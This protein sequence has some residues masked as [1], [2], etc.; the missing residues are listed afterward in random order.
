M[1]TD[2]RQV[3][4][5]FGSPALSHLASVSVEY[6]TWATSYAGVLTAAAQAEAAHKTARAKFMLAARATGECRSMTEAETR[7]EADDT[8]A[9]LYLTRLTT[10]AVADSHLEKLRQLRA[11]CDN[12]RS[13]SS[14][15]K[16]LDRLHADGRTG[17]A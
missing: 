5:H 1:S 4:K 14:Y 11:Q 12:G 3:T 6:T 16:E 8:I 10:R 17:A 13:Y 15:E 2:P 9:D 7:A